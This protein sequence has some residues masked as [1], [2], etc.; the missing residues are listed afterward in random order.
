VAEA[1]EEDEG[2]EEQWKEVDEEDLM[3]RGGRERELTLSASVRRPWG[4]KEGASSASVV[5]YP[6]V[7]LT[8]AKE[9]EQE[10]LS[11]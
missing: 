9:E 6:V 8:R 10:G 1:V 3:R 7:N 5:N 4:S 11:L 2:E